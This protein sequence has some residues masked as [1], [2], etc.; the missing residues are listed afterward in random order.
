IYNRKKTWKFWL[1]IFAI[2]IGISSLFVTN[3]LVK[4]LAYEEK[5][6]IEIWAYATNQ[7]VNISDDGNFSLAIKVMESNTN[8]PIILADENDSILNYRNFKKLTKTDSLLIR[9]GVKKEKKITDEYLQKQLTIMKEQNEPI[10]IHVYEDYKQRLY[11]KDSILLTRLRYYPMFQLGLISLFM[12]IAYLAFSSSRK[13]EQ[14]Q[15]WAGMA[16]ETAHQLGTPLSSLMAWVELL[17]SKKET[18]DM[19][20]DMEKDVIRLETITDRFSKI[21]SKPTLENVNIV[22]LVEEA[23]AYLQSRFPDKVKMEVRFKKT[24]TLVAVS[25]VL[26]HWVIENICKNAVDAMK[27]EGKILIHILDEESNVKIHI[28]DTGRGIEPNILD[29]IFK[30]GVSSK[31]RGWGLGLSLS[32]RI[33]EE[34][35]KGKIFVKKSVE[36]EGTTFCISLPKKS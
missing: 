21:G 2:I 26:L 35:H 6:K 16:K 30:P 22:S 34:Y 33:I 19:V 32:K 28:Q 12:F 4:L 24:E 31:K 9:L 13:A 25:Q 29:S 1:L 10:E 17:K 18:K 5:K 20:L 23:I 15:V 11:Y 8:I 7:M 3:S 14:N 36:G 27:G